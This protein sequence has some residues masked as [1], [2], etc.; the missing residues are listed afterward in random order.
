MEK[1]WFPENCLRKERSEDPDFMM[2]IGAFVEQAVREEILATF[3]GALLK[4]M[5]QA[6]IKQALECV[7]VAR[8]IISHW[9]TDC[10]NSLLWTVRID[11]PTQFFYR[12]SQRS[13]AHQSLKTS[14]Q[15]VFLQC[16]HEI[17]RRSSDKQ[18]WE[19]PG[20]VWM[21]GKLYPQQNV[22]F[23]MFGSSSKLFHGA[24]STS[25]NSTCWNV[26]VHG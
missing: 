25:S 12:F 1:L 4:K 5:M 19:R 17:C 6:W 3:A 9:M 13:S 21:L 22:F 18:S 16:R 14:I 10:E 15:T 23:C 2:L 11:S 24:L 26:D 8:L 20:G 7:R